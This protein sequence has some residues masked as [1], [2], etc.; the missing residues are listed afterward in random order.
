MGEGLGGGRHADGPIEMGVR[1]WVDI[2]GLGRM[3]PRGEMYM[4]VCKGKGRE[5][6]GGDIRI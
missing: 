1:N 3:K 6:V 5:W 4:G 2:N